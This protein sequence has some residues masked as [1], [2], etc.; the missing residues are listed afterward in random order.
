MMQCR[1]AARFSF[2]KLP[3]NVPDLD[4]ALA[5]LPTVARYNAKIGGMIWS[6]PNLS[7]LSKTG[8]AC[9]AVTRQEQN[10]TER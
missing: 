10:Q 5:Y 7:Q 9:A 8:T 4:G 1:R 3:R 6:P 2:E